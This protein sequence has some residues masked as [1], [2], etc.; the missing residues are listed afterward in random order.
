MRNEQIEKNR[1]VLPNF[2]L[3]N[4]PIPTFSYPTYPR[5]TFRHPAYTRPTAP[6]SKLEKQK[7]EVESMKLGMEQEFARVRSK[8]LFKSQERLNV[9]PEKEWDKLKKKI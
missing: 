6:W 1:P 9:I 8:Q 2:T 5:P 4:Y 7:K 3:P